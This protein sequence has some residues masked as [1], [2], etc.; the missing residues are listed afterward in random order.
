[1]DDDYDSD[2]GTNNKDKLKPR[3][4]VIKCSYC[5]TVKISNSMRYIFNLR[6]K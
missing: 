6:N 4:N 3:R 2:D 5:L 1:M